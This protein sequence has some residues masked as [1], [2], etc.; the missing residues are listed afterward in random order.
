MNDREPAAT[1]QDVPRQR[2]LHV[3]ATRGAAAPLLFANFLLSHRLLD[4]GLQP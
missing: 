4:R 1:V 2:V 3:K